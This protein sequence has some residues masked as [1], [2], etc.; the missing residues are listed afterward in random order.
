MWPTTRLSELIGIDYPIIQ[1][2]MAG[3]ST[4]ALAA[5][6][7][8]AGG[9][10]SLGCAFHTPEKVREALRETRGATNRPV[11]VNFFVHEPPRRDD[12]R[13]DRFRSLLDPY[14]EELG[15]GEPPP[16]AEPM[17]PFGEA[18]LEVVLEEGPR[19][20]SFHYGL[21]KA[22]HVAAIKQAAAAVLSTATTVSEAKIL[23]E[24]GVDAVIAQ[25]FEAGGH[26]GT[27]AAP[28]EAAQVGAMALVPQIADAVD[29]PVIAAGGIADGRGIAAAFALGASGVQMGTAFVSCPESAA[30]DLYRQALRDSR[31]DGTRLSRAFSGRPARWLLNRYVA[32]MA[33]HADSIPDYPLPSSQTA[34]LAAASYQR[35]SHD[36]ANMLAGQAA[37]LNREL[38]AADLVKV[39]IDET[40]AV[41]ARQAA[42]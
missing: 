16:L 25:G 22:E 36:F 18:M 17:A 20:V 13:E 41:L 34:P 1:A 8:N 19:V 32:E 24:R 29:V 11:N 26:R 3:A 10:G 27:F 38:P 12:A 4:P 6:V 39:L 14:Y 40:E 35:G 2:P 15:I 42:R 9:L 31:D 23:A 37:P 28:H 21:P 33:E 30:R 7:S 5:A